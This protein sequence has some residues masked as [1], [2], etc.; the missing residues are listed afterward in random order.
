MT[1]DALPLLAGFRAAFREG[2]DE[3]AVAA[4]TDYLLEQGAT[5]ADVLRLYAGNPPEWLGEAWDEDEGLRAVLAL[6]CERSEPGRK[7]EVFHPFGWPEEACEFRWEA[8]RR[9][10]GAEVEQAMTAAR[11]ELRRLCLQ[12]M[13]RTTSAQY[14]ALWRERT[15]SPRRAQKRRVLNLF[16]D[17]SGLPTINEPVTAS[18]KLWAAQCL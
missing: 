2:P 1:L 16:G 3:S 5:L 10:D 4:C 6:W 15:G 18:N 17:I 13:A 14:A 11:E 12:S 9:C 8:V 7:Q